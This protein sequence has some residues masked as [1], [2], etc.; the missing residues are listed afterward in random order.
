MSSTA[1][2]PD[3]GYNCVKWATPEEQQARFVSQQI[4]GAS[5]ATFGIVF[6]ALGLGWSFGSFRA[7]G[8][9]TSMISLISGAV[10]TGTGIYVAKTAST[11]A[12]YT[13]KT[14]QLLIAG[15]CA[16]SAPMIIWLIQ[17]LA[18]WSR[19]SRMMQSRFVKI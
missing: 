17:T 4:Q 6:L 7:P 18:L 1:S 8:P 2:Y 19:Q 16:I 14:Q 9:G 11:D 3:M 5:I 12:A 15:W 10:A 13:E